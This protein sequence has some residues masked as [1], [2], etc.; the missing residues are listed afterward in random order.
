MQRKAVCTNDDAQRCLLWLEPNISFSGYKIKSILCA[1]FS[2]IHE[3]RN[4][5]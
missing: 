5:L 1:A 3:K 2:L 4:A